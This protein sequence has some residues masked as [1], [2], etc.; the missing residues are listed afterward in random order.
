MYV[1]RRCTDMDAA[2]AP[3]ETR[4]FT[5]PRAPSCSFSLPGTHPYHQLRHPLHAFLIIYMC[6]D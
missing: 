5:L 6:R 3:A 1:G 2:T 4:L